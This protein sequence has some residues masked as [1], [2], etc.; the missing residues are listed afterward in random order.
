MKRFVTYLYE[1][2]GGQKTKNTGFIRV[3]IRKDKVNLEVCIKNITHSIGK[4]LIYGFV[5]LD[6]LLAIELGEIEVLNGQSETRLILSKDNLNESGYSI[7]SLYGVGICFPNQKYLASCW[8]DEITD[9]IGKGEFSVL[10]KE[11]KEMQA[12]EINEPIVLEEIVEAEDLPEF[13][14]EKDLPELHTEKDLSEFHIEDDELQN[15]YVTYEKIELKEI[16]N[17]SSSN[18][19]LCNNSFLV[20]GFFN[21]GYLI[22]KKKMEGDKESISLGVPGFFEKP[23]MVMAILYGFSNFEAIPKKVIEMSMQVE[24]IPYEI[25]ENQ[26]PETGIFGGWFVSLQN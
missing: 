11:E 1:Y 21:Y 3:D 26:K 19:H 6:D 24:S 25:E 9:Q 5:E 17:L 23:E 2:K 4:G 12:A 7:E 14:I 18:W 22:L 20:H 16:R 10:R 13:H 8:R 15:S